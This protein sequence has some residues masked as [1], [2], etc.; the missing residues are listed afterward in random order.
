MYPPATKCA[1]GFTTCPSGFVTVW[2]LSCVLGL[3]SP[4]SRDCVNEAS[5]ERGVEAWICAGAKFPKAG[6]TVMKRRHPVARKWQASEFDDGM[7][8]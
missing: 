1:H 8:T 3:T 7:C 2:C 5:I 4:I 6:G